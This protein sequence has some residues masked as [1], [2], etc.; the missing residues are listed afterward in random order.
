MPRAV[1]KS[2]VTRSPVDDL[3][4]LIRGEGESRPLAGRECAECSCLRAPVEKVRVGH[5]GQRPPQI[6]IALPDSDQPVCARVR[7]RAQHDGV[8][9]R[10]DRGVGANAERQGE[11]RHCREPGV[12]RQAAAGVGD[13]LPQL[14]DEAEAKRVPAAILDV[15]DAAERADRRRTRIV[16][17]E[18]CGEVLLDLSIEV[19]L[20]LGVELVFDARAC[21]QRTE[22]RD[23][24]VDPAHG[25]PQVIRRTRAI[26]LDRRSQFASSR[27]SRFRPARVSR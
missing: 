17:G 11:D 23:D 9:D 12:A 24:P 14:V 10:E 7:E 27:S 15:G 21:E 22:P 1:R 2:A 8:H 20:Q 18:A 26:A 13:I 5:R 4:T 6:R 19:E 25:D 16:G 3:R